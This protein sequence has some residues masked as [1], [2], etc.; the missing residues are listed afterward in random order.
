MNLKLE[1]MLPISFLVKSPI[2]SQRKEKFL[3]KLS[4]SLFKII[5]NS[6]L[7]TSS[8]TSDA[9]QSITVMTI[10]MSR[11]ASRLTYTSLIH[12]LKRSR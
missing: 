2:P 9:S 11:S 12:L 6:C 1:L 10:F 7:W 4:E 8:L 3:R 5:A